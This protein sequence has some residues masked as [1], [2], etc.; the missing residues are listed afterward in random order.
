MHA[1]AGAEPSPVPE[2]ARGSAELSVE[3]E[4]WSNVDGVEDAIPTAVAEALRHVYGE[5]AGRCVSVALLSDASVRSLNK[6]F[7][8]KD[9]A[10]N[11]L[12]FAPA[13]VPAATREPG[14]VFLG[15]VALA[16]ETVAAEA[17]AQA[18]PVLHHTMHLVV[19]GVLHLA[20]YGHEADAEADAMEGA[21]RAILSRLGVPDPYTES[22]A[23][24]FEA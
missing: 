19:H 4:R 16:Y 11:V 24:E 1:E 7:R 6:L 21:E 14:P 22:T 10:T 23:F 2:P 3:D 17:E 20:G 8:G 18:K 12:S 15:D 13:P 9:S 5:S